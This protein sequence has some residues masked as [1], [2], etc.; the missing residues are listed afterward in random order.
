MAKTS[1][2]G[3]GSKRALVPMT[4]MI[5]S[6]NMKEAGRVGAWKR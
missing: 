3:C 6:R 5:K 4:M 2:E 1:K